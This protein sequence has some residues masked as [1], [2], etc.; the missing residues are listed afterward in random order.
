MK[1]DVKKA[2]SLIDRTVRWVRVWH[3]PRAC[4]HA[5]RG[6]RGVHG[7]EPSTSLDEHQ[8]QRVCHPVHDPATGPGRQDPDAGPGNCPLDSRT[9]GPTGV[10]LG[11]TTREEVTQP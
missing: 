5:R 9:E 8:C 7:P 10:T 4:H 3:L 2:S 6:C 1:V 11:R